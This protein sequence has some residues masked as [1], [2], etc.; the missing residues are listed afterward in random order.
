MKKLIILLCLSM[1]SFGSMA[2]GFPQSTFS[3]QRALVSKSKQINLAQ[4]VEE[5][6]ADIADK[7]E[8]QKTSFMQSVVETI[9][10]FLV[11]VFTSP[12][13]SHKSV[14]VNDLKTKS[15]LY[16]QNIATKTEKNFII[17]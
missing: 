4:K 7:V 6:K 14:A 17:G 8:N 2:M 16:Q 9:G 5:V 12:F 15:N 3:Q 13:T 10:N 1:M 11:R